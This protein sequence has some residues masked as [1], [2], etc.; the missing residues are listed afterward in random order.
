MKRFILA[1]ALA[2]TTIAA[3]A[4]AAS[5]KFKMDIEYSSKNFATRSGAEAEYA[6]IQ[7]QVADRCTNENAELTFA[8]EYAQ[9]FCVR[10]T[11]NSAVSMIGNKT[12]TQ[13]HLERR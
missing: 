1:A 6:N 13:V 7:K 3:P 8:K 10:K 11:M 9:N 5:D 2:A 4:L 12:L